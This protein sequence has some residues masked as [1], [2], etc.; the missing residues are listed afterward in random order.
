M[1]EPWRVWITPADWDVLERHLFPGDR[2]EH[3]AVLRC[4]VVR[5][6]RESRLL[7]HDMVLARDGVD[8]VPGTRGYR[9]LTPEFVLDA[10]ESCAED[11]LVYVAVHC[12]GG[13]DEVAFSPTD[14]NSHARGYPA[15]LD[16]TGAP[17]VGALVFARNAVAG[18]IWPAEGGTARVE[19]LRV[20][21]RPE[22]RLHP[23]P[24]TPARAAE[25]YDRQARIFGD[26]GQGLLSQ[27]RIGI[28]GLGGA[29]SLINEYLARLGVGELVLVDPDRIETSNLSR[30]VGAHRRDAWGVLTDESRPGWLQALGRRL[31]TPK[32]TIA[33]RVSHQAS[34]RTHVITMQRDV[35][36]PEAADLLRGCDHIFLAAD[37]HAA[38]RLVDALTHQYFIPNTQVGAKVN[39]DPDTGEILDMF[40]VSRMSYPGSGCLRCNGLILPRVLQEE[41]LSDGERRRQRYIDDDDIH[42]PSVITLNAVAAAHAV[43]DWLMSVTGLIIPG[44]DLDRWVSFRPLTDEVDV[45]GRRRDP[46]CPSCGPA[47]FGRGDAVRLPVRVGS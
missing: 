35:T 44:L 6:R 40:S 14:L 37:S 47:R 42:A 19:E 1:N 46:N 22:R 27:L 21:G 38:R 10:A 16:I 15:L 30:V 5:T 34:S 17:A 11:G 33:A 3:A 26:R 9:R 36:D 28:V 4:A 24:I 39:V 41:A 31:A 18:D 25:G 45:Y 13:R 8:Y 43:N 7:V 12:H 29:G 2:D 23:A 20:V 32:V